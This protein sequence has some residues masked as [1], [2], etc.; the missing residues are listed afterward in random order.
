VDV[1]QKVIEVFTLQNGS[2]MTA[3]S[4]TAGQSAVSEVLD[5]FSISVET[6]CVW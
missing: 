4:Y 6:V 1:E 5:S 3:G 2:Y